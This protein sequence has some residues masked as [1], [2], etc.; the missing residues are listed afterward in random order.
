MSCPHCKRSLESD[1]DHRMC[2]VTMLK[3]GTIQS[4]SEWE[5]LCYAKPKKPLKWIRAW[6]PKEPSNSPGTPE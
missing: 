5:K 2:V 6:V 4:V 3:N 1:A